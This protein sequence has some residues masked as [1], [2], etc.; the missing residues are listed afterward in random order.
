MTTLLLIRHGETEYNRNGKMAGR[1]PGVPLNER[2]R[3]QAAEVA[4]ALAKAPIKTIYASPIER[5]QETASYLAKIIGLEIQIA[6]GINETDIGEWTGRSV[7]Q[8]ARTKLWQ[9]VI[10][11]P[12]ELTFPGGESF[13]YIQQRA[14]AEL[15]AIAERHPDELVAC[16]T[17][18]DI[19]RLAVAHFLDMPLDAFQR[20]GSDNCSITVLHFSKEGRVSIPKINQGVSAAWPEAHEK[21]PKNGKVPAKPQ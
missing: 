7:K 15:K 6:E 18:A 21:K 8:C 19:I 1:M 9:T 5:A 12:S 4:E 16:F 17:H 2:G 10:H 11:K 14:S 13:A 20:L 3:K